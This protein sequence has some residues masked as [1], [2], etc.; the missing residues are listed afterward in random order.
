MNAE[1][2]SSVLNG[3]YLRY[4]SSG[5]VTADNE[6]MFDSSDGDDEKSAEE[7]DRS[8]AIYMCKEAAPTT[9]TTLYV[10][11]DEMEDSEDERRPQTIFEKYGL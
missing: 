2:T 11:R 8:K 9:L 5:T 10:E 1:N 6:Y 4:D 3:Y 7:F